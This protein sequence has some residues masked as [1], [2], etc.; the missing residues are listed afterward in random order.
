MRVEEQPGPADNL[1]HGAA[2]RRDHRRPAGDRLGRGKP[3][4]FAERR[5]RDRQRVGIER[6]KDRVGYEAGEMDLTGQAIRLPNACSSSTLRMEAITLGIPGEDEIDVA[7]RGLSRPLSVP[8]DQP[9][10]IFCAAPAPHI[11]DEAAVERQ[12]QALASRAP[13]FFGIYRLEA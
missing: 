11:E 2:L 6:G 4:A 3:E 10:E 1:G 8:F 7:S 12:V 9:G 13:C 5:H